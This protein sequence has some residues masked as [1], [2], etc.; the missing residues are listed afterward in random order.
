[1]TLVGQDLVGPR[2]VHQTGDNP[3]WRAEVPK[4]PMQSE[5]VERTEAK[6]GVELGECDDP[7]T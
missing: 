5:G 4:G 1:M 6:Q 7:F 3:R 2:A